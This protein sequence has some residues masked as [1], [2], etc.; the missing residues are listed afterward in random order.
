MTSNS[1]VSRGHL[2]LVPPPRPADEAAAFYDRTIRAAWCLALHLH[3]R[4]T[5]RAGDAVVEAY[6]SVWAAG[7]GARDQAA[8]LH[9]LVIST[10]RGRDPLPDP[11]PA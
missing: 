11:V 5:R 7:P 2:R 10:R 3:D 8:L 4:D 6:R 9:A 1:C